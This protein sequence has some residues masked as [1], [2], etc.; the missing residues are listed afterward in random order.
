MQKRV[1]KIDDDDEASPENTISI[2][3]KQN[4]ETGGKIWEC[5][6][7]LAKYIKKQIENENL[8]FKGP[9]LELGSGTGVLTSDQPQIQQICEHNIK[10]NNLEIPYCILDWN[11]PKIKTQILLEQHKPEY[12][13]ASD[14]TYSIKA[15]EDFFNQLKIIYEI[16]PKLITYLSHKE[17]HSEI[18]N[19]LEDRFENIGL[20][21][22]QIKHQDLDEQWRSKNFT[23]YQL[24]KF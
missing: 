4:L 18:D 5:A 6:L 11:Q 17:R 21:F 2:F 3:E 8:S 16:N 20:W 19:S 7:I 24:G 22:K 10:K 14:V 23:V 1:I 12:I 13:L 15:A 9:I